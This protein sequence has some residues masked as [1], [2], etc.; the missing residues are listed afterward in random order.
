MVVVDG[1]QQCKDL[2]DRC[3]SLLVAIQD[4]HKGMEGSAAPQILELA[5]PCVDLFS[6]VF[7][8]SDA[9]HLTRLSDSHSIYVTH[10]H[11]HSAISQ[12]HV[13]LNHW[14]SLSKI[15]AFMQQ[16]DIKQAIDNSN[17]DLEMCF[18]KLLSEHSRHQ[19]QV[20]SFTVVS[21]RILALST[22]SFFLVVASFVMSY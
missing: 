20:P 16:N 2:G 9:F 15:K 7:L 6:A 13:R 18:R 17:R 10:L 19:S 4:V 11:T 22:F 3:V 12:I 14:S 1:K 21:S 8:F 5:D